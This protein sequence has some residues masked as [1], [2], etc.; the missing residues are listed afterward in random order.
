MLPSL[1][2][3][4][5]QRPTPTDAL[6]L[7]DLPDALY[8]KMLSDTG[9]A[10][11]ICAAVDALS[12]SATRFLD[13]DAWADIARN[14]EMPGQPT[15]PENATPLQI[16]TVWRKWVMM[17]CGMLRPVA[18][19]Y[20][21]ELSELR[22]NLDA[23]VLTRHVKAYK[24]VVNNTSQQVPLSMLR[25]HLALHVRNNGTV[26]LAEFILDRF[27][28]PELPTYR[29]MLLN[30]CRDAALGP[31]TPPA[32]QLVV[33]GLTIPLPRVDRG[34]LVS[35]LLDK[36]VEGARARAEKDMR[37][38]GV[39]YTDE[40]RQ[41][42]LGKAINSSVQRIY[43]VIAETRYFSVRSAWPL[44]DQQGYQPDPRPLKTA[45]AEAVKSDDTDVMRWLDTTYGVSPDV[46]T[47]V[48]TS[49]LLPQHATMGGGPGLTLLREW[50]ARA[51]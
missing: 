22:I 49:I 11:A 3:L 20:A 30:A 40:E 16:V 51:V 33:V 12:R 47:D 27:R 24:W 7:D 18:G 35:F 13:M 6:T 15:I 5:V 48:A 45:I 28:I 50:E 19:L 31:E 37:L 8:A 36:V 41:D 1:A 2:G 43:E 34:P 46:A 23:F 29:R 32:Q 10:T 44:I 4:R 38:S 14:F 26:D 17:W 25:E 21:G 42:E 39:E 9:S